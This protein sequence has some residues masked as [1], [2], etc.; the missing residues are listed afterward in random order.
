MPT[1]GDERATIEGD[2]RPGRAAA[3]RATIAIMIAT[4][5]IGCERWQPETGGPSPAPTAQPVGH[6]S[7]HRVPDV[8]GSDDTAILLD[9]ITGQ[10]WVLCL[11]QPTEGQLRGSSRKWCPL[12]QL[13][14]GPTK[15]A[16]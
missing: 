8:M 11:Y 2:R 14:P 6:F 4:A 7:I 5:L 1:D 15:P 12:A 10:T 16:P 13:S 3:A 9:T